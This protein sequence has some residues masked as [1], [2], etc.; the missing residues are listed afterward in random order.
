MAITRRCKQNNYR[1]TKKGVIT[2]ITVYIIC[3]NHSKPAG[4]WG[5]IIYIWYAQLANYILI[6]THISNKH[7]AFVFVFLRIIAKY[8]RNFGEVWFSYYFNEKKGEVFVFTRK[9]ERKNF[10]KLIR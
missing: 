4:F 8:N 5:T 7:N 2:L 10:G 3:D 1:L 9:K 6:M